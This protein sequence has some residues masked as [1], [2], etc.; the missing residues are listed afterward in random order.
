MTQNLFLK[1]FR[2]ALL[3][4]L[5]FGFFS[6]GKTGAATGASG[7]VPDGEDPDLT[8]L[9]TFD[10]K[11][12]AA[13]YAKG[14]RN[15]TTF[16]DNLE[17]RT[18]Q[19]FNDLNAFYI[20][21][22]EKLEY[23]VV[24]NINPKEGTLTMW[25]MARNYDPGAVTNAD[26]EKCH[27]SYA[28]IH[29][30][31]GDNKMDLYLYQYYS[32]PLAYFYWNSSYADKYK[33][34][35]IPVDN[36]HEKRWFQIAVTWTDKAIKTYLN[37]ELQNQT[38]LPEGAKL[39]AKI[40]PE[41]DKS[42]IA[43]RGR[44]WGDEGADFGKD[45]AVDD[46]RI[47]SRALGDVEI[48]KQFLKAA[49][50]SF[51]VSKQD[52]TSIGL[53]LTGVDDGVGPLDRLCV[54]VDYQALDKGWRALLADGKLK[55]EL[56]ITRP[57]G[58]VVSDKWIPKTLKESRIVKEITVPGK[59][60]VLLTLSNPEG[61]IEKTTQSIVRPDTSWYRNQLGLGSEV[62]SP[63]EPVKVTQNQ[64][65]SVWGR[66]YKFDGK[67]FPQS[68]LHGSDE[69]LA[70]P[71]ELI[72]QKGGEKVALQY[73]VKNQKGDATYV[74]FSGT[75]E[76][77]GIALDWKTRVEFDGLIR[78]D[79]EIHGKPKID[80]M[81]LEWTVKRQFSEFILNPLLK[82]TGNGIYQTAFP[83]S[84]AK[85]TVLWLTSE[86]KGFC[87]MPE[88]DANW[89]Y[90]SKEDQ[91]I[92]ANV[93]DKGGR[94]SITMVNRE[95]TIPEGA[96]YHAMWIATP[97][98]ALPKKTRTYRFGGFGRYSNCDV[99]L[100]Q[101]VG[102]GTDG[103]FSL[104]PGPK[105]AEYMERLRKG[106]MEKL[107]IYG[108]AT[109]LQDH[110]AEGNYF[111]VYWEIPGLGQGLW[112]N[113]YDNII[114]NATNPCPHTAYSDYI[115]SNIK[116]LLDHPAQRYAAIYY[117]L[118]NNFRCESSLHGCQFQDAFG[119][120]ISRF[121]IMGLRKHMMRT[122]AY[123]HSRGRD[124]IYHAHSC[125]NPAIHDFADYWFPGE[126]YSDEI[127][128]AN[129]PY[130]YSDILDDDVYRSELS[131]S[132]KGTSI[133]FLG[134]LKRANINYGDED[135]TIAMCTKLLLNDIPISMSSFEDGAVIN[136]IWGIA[137]KYEL[138]T[139]QVVKYYEPENVVKS[140]NPNVKVTYYKC[141]G[142][143]RL[144]I[145]GNIT[146]T[147]QSAELDLSALG[148]KGKVVHDEYNGK[149]IPIENGKLKLSLA[150]RRFAEIGFKAAE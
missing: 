25:L 64:T 32:L 80:Q 115:L 38:P 104:K 136:R 1:K 109:G 44:L 66:T 89:I 120:T 46:I 135:Q 110:C 6:D 40:K 63:W 149:D 79:F 93:D 59:Y 55:A 23:D 3:L 70:A 2:L 84:E 86:K 51:G 73:K 53:E 113:D 146:A 98:R 77:K 29:F 49:P 36:I 37:G 142:N 117:D 121:I 48:K 43:I 130:Y 123:C 81:K 126:Q 27:K 140:S 116:L 118:C 150:P 105:F 68:V 34:A 15:S 100:V 54:G 57:D 33:L 12:V 131:S 127:Q 19:G 96:S 17:F 92:V 20:K 95:V 147:E 41:S 13:D 125:Y 137:L 50:A 101:H 83:H 4:A 119:R 138:D 39:A 102:E 71:P 21:D 145:I 18:L 128:K 141:N 85:G 22:R 31:E 9:L 114:A 75:G 45:T 69:L 52:L 35:G 76:G 111:K 60:E 133:L 47:Y 134:N 90:D 103:V 106:N 122:L 8:F 58:K 65:V 11:S 107:A 88:H 132:L 74:E 143:K 42:F 7:K 91:S 129:T 56:A 148:C 10:R 87:W 144:L 112:K 62:P 97:S 14:D 16:T 82:N 94:C 78:T 72:I 99:A 5:I 26:P 67:P 124:T 61:K 108:G 30:Q 24:N 139:A 28:Y